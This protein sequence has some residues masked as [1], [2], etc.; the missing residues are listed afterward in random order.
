MATKKGTPPETDEN[1][2]ST[3]A[4]SPSDREAF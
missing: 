4:T 2:G 3:P 1:V